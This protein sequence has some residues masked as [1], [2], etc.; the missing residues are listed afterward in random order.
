MVV[1]LAGKKFNTKLSP[2]SHKIIT[3]LKP[4]NIFLINTLRSFIKLAVAFTRCGWN[5]GVFKKNI[6]S[7]KIFGWKTDHIIPPN[8]LCPCFRASW[9]L[10]KFNWASDFSKFSSQIL[11]RTLSGGYFW[12]KNIFF[13]FLGFKLKFYFLCCFIEQH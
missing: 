10:V 5:Q 9:Y 12:K 4:A 3:K 13:F 6:V 11:C 2:V 7:S 1:V 8:H